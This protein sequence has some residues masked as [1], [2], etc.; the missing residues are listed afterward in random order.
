MT[1]KALNTFYFDTGVQIARYPRLFDGQVAIN[2]TKQIPFDADA[3]IDSHLICLC[4]NPTLLHRLA[5]GVIVREVFNTTI[6]VKYAYLRLP[7]N[8]D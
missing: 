5:P 2:G 7:I 6:G 8:Y 1:D 4:D 3:P